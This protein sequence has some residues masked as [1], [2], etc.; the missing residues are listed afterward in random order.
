MRRKA[1]RTGASRPR[2]P[3]AE[4]RPVFVLGGGLRTGSTLLQRL[5]ISSGDILIWGEHDGALVPHLASLLDDMQR[6]LESRATPL[7]D[8]ATFRRSGYNAWIPNMNPPPGHFEDGCRALLAR[9]LGDPARALGYPRWGFKEVR[10]GAAAAL[11]LQKLY[12]NAAFIL[13][14]RDPRECLQSLLS[15]KWGEEV[16]RKGDPITFLRTWAR[17]SEE[18]LEVG[19]RLNKV[20][21]IRYQEILRN[22]AAVLDRV[23]AVT[24]IPVDRFKSDEVLGHREGGP[25]AKHFELTDADRRA[26]EDPEV[27]RVAALLGY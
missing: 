5:L 23:S 15:T 10:Y 1:S 17:L 25:R 16:A 6:W 24:E 14:V 27:R 9:A 4:G 22:T 2:K 13:L 7:V 26:L 11:F 20:A 21:L 18:L 3:L 19:S 12:P 8:L